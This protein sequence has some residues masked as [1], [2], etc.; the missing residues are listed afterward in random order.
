M[1]PSFGTLALAAAVGSLIA[2][3]SS[4]AAF[5]QAQ[6]PCA[7]KAGNPC[8]TKAGNPCAPKN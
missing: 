6:N 8:A 4:G 5:A 3:G 7:A 1:S 2:L